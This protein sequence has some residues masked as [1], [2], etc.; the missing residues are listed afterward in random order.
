MSK[1]GECFI[2]KILQILIQTN[3]LRLPASHTGRLQSASI[4]GCSIILSLPKDAASSNRWFDK[5]TMS[6]LKLTLQSFYRPCL[7]VDTFRCPLL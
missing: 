2:L 7:P 3:T 1:I 4:C 6:R 5:L